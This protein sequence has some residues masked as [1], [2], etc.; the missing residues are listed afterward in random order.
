MKKVYRV[1][2]CVLLLAA[3][4]VTVSAAASAQMTVSA[5]KTT[6]YRGD[7]IEFTVRISTVDDCRSAAFMLT[8]D[9]DVFEFVSGSCSLSGTSLAN[10]SSGTGTFAYS[11]G[12]TVSGEIF[13]FRLKVKSD[14]VIG[15]YRIS[16]NVNTR[17]SNGAIPTTVNS[18]SITV[19]CN[20]SYGPWSELDNAKHK[21]N[22]TICGNE[23]TANH[24]WNSGTEVKA[25]NCKEG[26]Q[27]RYTCTECAA[28]KT[29]DTPKSNDHKYGAWT[30]S[31]SGHQQACAVCGDVK[32]GSHTWDGGTAIKE[33]NCVEG[34]QTKYTCTGCFATKTEDTPK[35]NDHKY[36]NWENTSDTAHKHI[37][38]VCR[39]EETANHSWDG[40]TVTKKATCKEDGV[41]TVTCTGCAATKTEQIPKLTTHTYDHGC[42]NDCNVCGLSRT[43]THKYS[44]AWSKDKASH[45]HECSE[46]KEKKDT[47]A[48]TPGA[49]AT[50]TT[51]Q[52]CTVC[53]Y[54][55]KAALGHTHSYADSW[56]TDGEGHWYACSGCEER[57]SYADHDFENVCDADCSVCGGTRETGH[58]YEGG[59]TSDETG[60]WQVCVGCG[61]K[62]DEAAHVPGVEA[63]AATAQTCT[64]CAYE[65]APALGG[66]ATEMTDSTELTTPAG[67]GEAEK[68]GSLWWILVLAGVAV[69]GGAAAVVAV[70]KKKA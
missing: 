35:T 9:K 16:A 45:W 46:C 44:G 12:T 24:T 55:M 41:K 21:H 43:T 3:M 64:V 70:K 17:D 10:F 29:E 39:K 18:L 11:S 59:W 47:A 7:T 1:L 54:I 30:E 63:T 6:A 31:G 68:D 40:G 25:A 67:D 27:I 53:G 23:E 26:G 50:E 66:E 42:D 69:A 20:H 60:H 5:S 62:A 56:T 13:T 36:G 14:A 48:H 38:S 37:C 58:T 52:T 32:T 65:I 2:L 4:A 61:L 19:A 8:Y 33:A 57:G 15:D 22:C 28:T 34:G 49:E 51:A